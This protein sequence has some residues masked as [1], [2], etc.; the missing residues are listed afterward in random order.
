MKERNKF[1]TFHNYI[2]EC[3]LRK[4]INGCNIFVESLYKYNNNKK[5]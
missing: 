4:S 2:N 1:H 5:V 3:K